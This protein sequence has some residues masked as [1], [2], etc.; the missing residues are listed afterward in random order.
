MRATFV[1]LLVAFAFPLLA[2]TP[3]I[4][5]GRALFD[6][7]DYEKAAAVLEKAIAATPKSADAHYLLGAAYGQQA[8]TASIFGQMSLA[9]KSREQLEEAV[10]L[11]P[12]HLDARMG[13]LQFFNMAP[14][15]AGGSESKAM[16][17]AAEIKK[18]D[19]VRGAAAYA[20]IY[21]HDKKP[22]LAR[23]EYV[24]LVRANP[25]SPKAHLALGVQYIIDKN[26]AAASTEVETAQKLD[27]NYQQAWF[28]VGQLAVLAGN[29][30]ARG[31]EALRK[32]LA[33]TPKQN[34]VPV[35][36]AHFW[37]GQI[38]EKSG[39]KAEAKAAYEASL[40]L[41]GEQKDVIEALKRVS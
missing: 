21:N 24:D 35:Y 25:N 11:D 13:L 27:P 6:K 37:L 9:G 17:Q 10:R 3:L 26:Y 12:N 30:Y 18:R 1:T 36:R 14:S 16:E 32:Y 23:K 20:S 28:R 31:E 19:A 29:N 15:I 22:E 34:E 41:R 38:L 5:Q 40:K 39:H 7:G 8:M 2:Q 33:Y 4:D